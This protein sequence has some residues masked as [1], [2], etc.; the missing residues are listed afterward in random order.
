MASGVGMSSQGGALAA[1]GVHRPQVRAQKTV[2]LRA[3][4]MLQACCSEQDSKPG[5]ATSVQVGSE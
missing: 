2:A 3:P 1:L 5:G 4:H